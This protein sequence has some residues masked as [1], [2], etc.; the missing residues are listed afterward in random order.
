MSRKHSRSGEM[1]KVVQMARAPVVEDDP[2][3]TLIARARRLR[4]RGDARGALVLMRQACSLDEWRARP[5]TLLGV[6]LSRT[7]RFEEAARA[8]GH[9]RWLRVRAGE[10][11]RAR[12]T[13]RLLS[14]VQ[15]R[16]RAA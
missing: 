4:R 6:M 16:T 3:E 14:D 15:A 2:V 10:T 9:A 5:F 11:A 7:G 13:E 12:V 8:L 1:G